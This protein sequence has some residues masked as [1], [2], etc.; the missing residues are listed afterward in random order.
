MIESRLEGSIE[1]TYSEEHRVGDHIC[2]I[3]D[4]RRFKMDY[5]GWAICHR[6]SDTVD[7]MIDAEVHRG[8]VLGAGT[9]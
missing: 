6:L 2:Y 4:V 7:Q 5:P 8:K 9:S 3:S 1:W